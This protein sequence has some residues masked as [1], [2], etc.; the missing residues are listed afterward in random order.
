[1]KKLSLLTLALSVSTTPM[2]A[3]AKITTATLYPSHAELTWQ[4]SRQVSA[5]AGMIEIEGLPLSLQDQSLQIQL[6]GMPSAQVHQI[7]VSRAEHEEFVADETRRIRDEL[8]EVTLRIQEHEDLIRAWQ[9]QVTLM[10]HAS[11]S[12]HELTA[13]ELQEMAAAVKGTTQTALAEIRAI[14]V[15]MKSD[16]ALKERLTRELSQVTQS[17]K[18]AKNVRIHYRAP[19]SGLVQ[20]KLRFQTPEASWRSEYNARLHTEAELGGEL[21]LEHV[22]VVRQTTGYDW[23]DVELHLA[24]ANARKGTS[25]PDV[26]SW[27]VSPRQPE[28]YQSKMQ[29]VM[30]AEMEEMRAASLMAD[31]AV[32]DRISTFTQSYSLAENV[33]LPSGSS[34]QRFRVADHSVPVEVAVWSAPVLDPTGYIHAKGQFK[35]NA[36]IPA[37]PA[38]LYRDGQSVGQTHLGGLADGE[39]L[40]LGFGVDEA[41][42]ISVINELERTGE[43]GIWSSENVQRRQNRFEITNHHDTPVQIRLFDRLPVSEQD[44]LT[45]KSLEIS[46]PVQRNFAEKKGVLSWEREVPAGKTISVKSGFEVRVPEGTSLPRL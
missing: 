11:Q 25:M 19:E 7:Q 46:E 38:T 15:V 30:E 20:V 40:A 36:P 31:S 34:K 43:E 12:A 39:E 4:E 10:S 1:M 41:V 13:T 45:V 26:T 22:A 5:G 28:R 6:E 14:R 21:T 23:D 33:Q 42:R 35:A 27:V 17:A 18:A 3:L 29:A 2:M 44:V 24:T 16:V 37:G 9:Q 32:V 8:S